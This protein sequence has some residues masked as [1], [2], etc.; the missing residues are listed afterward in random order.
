MISVIFTGISHPERSLPEFCFHH[1]SV[2][3][4]NTMLIVL[5]SDPGGFW[6]I[7]IRQLDLLNRT[8]NNF[9]LPGSFI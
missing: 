4:F 5:K 2:F 8:V 6:D 3:I 7:F 9:L 1:L